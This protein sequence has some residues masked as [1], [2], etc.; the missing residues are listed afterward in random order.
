MIPSR[1]AS[2]LAAVTESSSGSASVASIRAAVER[3]TS[4]GGL[5]VIGSGRHASRRLDDKRRR[6]PGRQGDPGTPLHGNGLVTVASLRPAA[7]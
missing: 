1:T 6:R 7:G 5:Y 4:L 2:N 3:I